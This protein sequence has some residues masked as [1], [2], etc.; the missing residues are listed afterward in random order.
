MSEQFSDNA[1]DDGDFNDASS[2]LMCPQSMTV[3]KPPRRNTKASKKRKNAGDSDMAAY[4]LS[5][6]K[7]NK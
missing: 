5:L 4:F 7:K 6:N 2:N 3:K 1:E